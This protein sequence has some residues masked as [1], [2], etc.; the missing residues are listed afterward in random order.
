MRSIAGLFALLLA[1]QASAQQA[2]DVALDSTSA[3]VETSQADTP[4]ETTQPETPPAEELI[5]GVLVTGEQPGPGLW[6]VLNGDRTLWILGTHTPLPKKMSWRSKQVEALVA[7][8]Q[9]VLTA[10]DVDFE[11]NIGFFRAMTLMPSMLG[12]RKN[13]DGKKLA[14]LLPGDVHD[15]WR[16][17]KEKYI[18]RGDGIEK[19]R[20]TFA[21]LELRSEALKESGLAYSSVWWPPIERAAKKHKVKVTSPSVEVQVVIDEPRQ[22]LK[23]FKQIP[24]D[25]VPCFT[26]TIDNLEAD[27][28]S[29]KELANAWAIG[30]VAALEKLHRDEPRQ[31]C[32]RMIF[33]MILEGGGVVS[34]LG[35]EEMIERT[36][37]AGELAEEE[38]EQK[39][40]AAAQTALEN[41]ETTVGVLPIAEL[42]KED[43]RLAKLRALGYTVRAP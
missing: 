4:V 39:W 36:R 23:R 22:V 2:A 20:P 25:D 1:A 11:A 6:R 34:E 14:D 38:L 31:D 42:V 8:S 35:I 7:R 3:P 10:G 19:W 41:N 9:E 12:A 24:L 40:L 27:I 33:T 13:P 28:A 37:R 29:L 5:E 17:L 30:D 32:L 16:V 26:V 18:G 21:A 15:R 43:G